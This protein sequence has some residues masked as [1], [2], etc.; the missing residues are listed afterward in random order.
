MTASK[1]TGK[2]SLS[3]NSSGSPQQKYYWS[4]RCRIKLEW[5]ELWDWF[6]FEH[7]ALGT[8]QRVTENGNETLAYFP[9]KNSKP[10]Q[11][12]HHDFN[13][14]ISGDAGGVQ[15]LELIQC[16]EEDWQSNWKPFFKPVRIG[17]NLQVMPPW[18]NTNETSSLT[19]IVI[20]PGRGFGTGYHLST[21]L[22]LELLE[23]FFEIPPE[24]HPWL[25]DFGTGSGILSIA[26]C[27]LG[28]DKSIA[29]DLD[30]GALTDVVRNAQLN[31]MENRIFPL[32]ADQVCLSK[33]FPVVIS[34]MLLSELQKSSVELASSLTYGGSLLCSG[35]LEEQTPELEMTFRDLGLA[36]YRRLKRDGWSALEFKKQVSKISTSNS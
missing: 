36:P 18:F 4:L 14:S 22:A 21:S 32:R 2:N 11:T 10:L 29:L 33:A 17:R 7:G 1:L 30:D 16:E 9:E 19:R 26:A 20:D 6:C 28:C 25:L 35:I 13:T 23:T 5:E 3:E 27:L 15:L 24:K 12:L 31:K 8:E 34:N